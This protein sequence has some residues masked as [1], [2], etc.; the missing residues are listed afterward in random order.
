M[1]VVALIHHEG[2]AYGVSFPD[3]PGCTTV[4]GDLDTAVAKA[5]EV[6]AF[7]AEGLAEDGPLPHPRSLSE[8]K[9]DSD[10][11][12]DAKHAVLVLVPYD[13]PTRAVRINVTLEESLLARIDRSADAAGETRSGYLAAA[14]RLRMGTPGKR[15]ISKSSRSL[16][17]HSSRNERAGGSKKERGRKR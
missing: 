16:A 17:R 13:P 2:D 4:A 3:F 11:C 15:L 9:S 14:A 8:L 7:H 6:L 5:A 1:Q 12:E 10:F